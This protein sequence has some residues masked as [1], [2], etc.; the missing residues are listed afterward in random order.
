MVG[1]AVGFCA[2]VSGCP[3]QHSASIDAKS[4]TYDSSEPDTISIRNEMIWDN[5]RQEVEDYVETMSMDYA[6]KMICCCSSGNYGYGIELEQ[7]RNQKIDN[8]SL[9]SKKVS[10]HDLCLLS[11]VIQNEAGSEWLSWEWKMKVGEILMNRVSSPEFPNTIEECLNQPGQYDLRNNIVP[12]ITSSRIA[13]ALLSGERI[14]NNP[15]VVFQANF[16]QG[17]GIYEVLHDR[18]LGDTY[19]CYSNNPN[20]YK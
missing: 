8:Y 5:H 3:V 2:T 10:F 13:F 11:K 14:I 6:D 19:L 18:T 20:L 15:A 17:S 16:P 7:L 9:T 1:A 4:I 12:S